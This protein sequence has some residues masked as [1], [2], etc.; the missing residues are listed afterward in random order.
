[1]RIT[2]RRGVIGGVSRREC[3]GLLI[4]I[5]VKVSLSPFH[6]SLH[7]PTL[8]DRDIT[9]VHLNFCPVPPQ[10]LLALIP[11]RTLL[12]I[13]PNWILSP[14]DRKR[15][16]SALTYLERGSGYY[17]LQAFTVRLSSILVGLSEDSIQPLQPRTIAYGL[18][19]SPIGLLA[20]IGE[21]VR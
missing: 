7:P 4:R 5:I 16:E 8:A 19:D 18:N 17:T 1:M 3:W 9:A 2:R 15:S 13:L 21:K 6:P 20:W 12:A 11:P 10:G 14:L